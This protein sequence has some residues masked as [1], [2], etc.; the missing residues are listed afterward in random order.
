MDMPASSLAGHILLLLELSNRSHVMANRGPKTIDPTPQ[1]IL[2]R[3]AKIRA[4]WSERTYRMRAGW[5]VEAAD[6]MEQ[7]VTPVVH[8]SDIVDAANDPEIANWAN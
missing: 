6:R 7:W 1:E 5:S 2:R 4:D 8:L 3:T